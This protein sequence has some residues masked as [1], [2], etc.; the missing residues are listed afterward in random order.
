MPVAIIATEHARRASDRGLTNEK[1]RR[2]RT[3]RA[4]P[5]KQDPFTSF[6]RFQ[7][8]KRPTGVKEHSPIMLLWPFGK[9]RSRTAENTGIYVF[10]RAFSG[11]FLGCTSVRAQPAP[12]VHR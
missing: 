9:R 10:A 4:R 12:R 1:I 8:A 7:P 11:G 5:R 6:G 3:A 2:S